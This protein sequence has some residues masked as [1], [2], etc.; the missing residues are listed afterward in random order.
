MSGFDIRNLAGFGGRPAMGCVLT[1][2]LGKRTDPAPTYVDMMQ[3]RPLLRNSA[4]PGFLGP[5]YKPFRPDLSSIFNRPL[6]PGMVNELAALGSNHTV[7]LSLNAELNA[8]RL[9][10]RN[11]LLLS[12][13]HI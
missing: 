12:L 13:I 1:K 7:S 8:Q 9:N 3:G 2:L 6:E 11:A 5:S 10:S 4:R